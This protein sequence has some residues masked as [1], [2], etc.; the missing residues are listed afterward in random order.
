[1]PKVGYIQ[2]GV[3]KAKNGRRKTHKKRRR[4]PA[5]IKVATKK[6][7]GTTKA[8]ALSFAKK[9]GMRLVSATSRNPRR[10]TRK[11]KRNGVVA[12]SR[13]RNG[14][15]GNSKRDARTVVSLLGGMGATKVI[16][17]I[18]A[19]FASPY[20]SQVGLGAYSELI[21][22]LGVALFVVPPIAG[23]IGNSGDAQ[24]ARLGG[25]AVAALEAVDKIGGPSL[26]FLNPFNSQPIVMASNGQA[27]LPPSTVSAIV[28]NT[29][30]SAADKAA[31]AGAMRAISQGVPVTSSPMGARVIG[32]LYD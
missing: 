27:A 11:R 17:R 6:R 10:K 20:L 8:G 2:N 9:N 29:N 22:D 1:M 24:T 15:F 13:T 26:S 19:N 12:V 4:N 16:G 14:I 25:L 7:N 18:V 3:T 5:A 32:P 28:N 30:A 21:A 31:V 23:K